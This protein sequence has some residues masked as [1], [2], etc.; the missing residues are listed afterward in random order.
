MNVPV[1][2][3][4]QNGAVRLVS[5]GRLK[6]S[7]LRPLTENHGE[8]TDLE[9]LEGAT[10]GRQLALSGARPAVGELVSGKFGESFINAAFSYARSNRFNDASRGAWYNSF[11]VETSLAEVSFH[12][13]RELGYTNY[14]NDSG[15][16]AELLSDVDSE[17]HDVRELPGPYLDPDISIG[18]PAGQALAAMLRGAGGA[19]IVYPSVRHKDG[20]CMALFHPG[21]VNNFRT[22]RLWRIAFTSP[23]SPPTITPDPK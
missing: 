18:Y 17:L 15:D 14:F 10:S 22:G 13:R 21:L 8:L 1:Q 5:S 3:I 4:Q 20:T 16:Y 2:R 23:D 9:E 11:G 12:R 19:G 6:D 7:V